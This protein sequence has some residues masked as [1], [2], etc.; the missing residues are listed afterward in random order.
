M[1]RLIVTFDS[2]QAL[3]MP[4]G[5]LVDIDIRDQIGNFDELE[6]RALADHPRMRRI[7]V[8][9]MPHWPL[10]CFYLHWSSGEDLTILDSLV[11]SG[12]ATQD[13]FAN[14]VLGEAI[15]MTCMECK[16]QLRVVTWSPA[17][18]LFT[19][20][21]TRAQSHSFKKKCPVCHHAWTASVLEFIDR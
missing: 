17:L 9:P 14:A 1:D 18:K 11:R 20:S 19:D 16:A 13:D 4:A 15:G 8:R 6:D 12:I 7:L 2:R 10:A 3:Y 5:H 21:N